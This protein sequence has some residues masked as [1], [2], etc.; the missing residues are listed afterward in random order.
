MKVMIFSDIH[1]DLGALERALAQTADIYIAAGDL[2][3]F[4]K[5]LERCGPLLAPLGERAWVLPGNHESHADTQAF[6]REFGLVD[7]HRQA[8]KVGS[9][10]WAGL[11]YSNITPFN[12][13]GEYTEEEIGVALG[14]FDSLSQFYLAVHVPPYGTVIDEYAP[15]KHGGSPALRKWV[16]RKSPLGLYCGH[17]HETAGR[18]DRVGKTPCFNVGKIGKI[19]EA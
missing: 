5:G 2:S 19:I 8:R 6:C 14:E 15:G 9:S 16:E 4:G 17:I 3:T 10:L 18:A 11:G 7:F 13:P 12:T 1:G